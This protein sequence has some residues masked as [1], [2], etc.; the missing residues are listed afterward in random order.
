MG[1]LC[2]DGWGDSKI[3]RHK[4]AATD[5]PTSI[6]CISWAGSGDASAWCSSWIDGSRTA[7]AG[8][9]ASPGRKSPCRFLS[10]PPLPPALAPSFITVTRRFGR[11]CFGCGCFGRRRGL[12]SH[13]DWKAPSP[14]RRPVRLGAAKAF[15]VPKPPLPPPNLAAAVAAASR[16]SSSRARPPAAAAPA[17]RPT[18]GGRAMVAGWLLAGIPP[19]SGSTR[20]ALPCRHTSDD[21]ESCAKQL[22]GGWIRA[23]HQV[24]IVVDDGVAY[25]PT[26]LSPIFCRFQINRSIDQKPA[27]IE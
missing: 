21:E 10:S 23:W 19:S 2:G 5:A 11:R 4:P 9:L 7:L 17:L 24:D 27:V 22:I 18:R 1:R 6:S 26:R 13:G 15:P 20:W 12:D 16:P 25:S 8:L 3:T 14:R